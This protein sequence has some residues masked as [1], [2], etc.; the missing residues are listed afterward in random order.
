MNLLKSNDPAP[1]RLYYKI[2]RLFY[3]LWFR[4]VLIIVF[5]I[6]SIFLSQKFLYKN[7][8]LNAEKVREALVNFIL[9][10]QCVDEFIARAHTNK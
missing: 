4:S 9:P 6:V 5:L 10:A 8:D 7:I 2:N 1:S 3:R